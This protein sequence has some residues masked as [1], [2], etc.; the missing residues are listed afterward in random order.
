MHNPK[1]TI[2]KIIR[3]RCWE[4]AAGKTTGSMISFHFGGK[5]PYKAP[6]GL[7]GNV[8]KFEG[9]F[10][11][12]LQDAAWR[13]DKNEKVVCSSEGLSLINNN[14]SGYQAL[15][16]LVGK[17]VL[18]VNVRNAG[19]DLKIGFSGG[20]L[21]QVLS[22]QTDEVMTNYSFH[23]PKEVIV[24]GPRGVVRREQRL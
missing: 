9:E 18:N 13:I 3:R 19:W 8:A 7:K 1:T 23:T 15:R 4:I 10:I 12:F 17:R 21:L 24:V 11:L 5:L 16:A 22:I 20:Y 2:K 6:P 14:R